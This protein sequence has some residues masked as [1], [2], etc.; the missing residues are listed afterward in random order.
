MS[1]KKTK[2]QFEN[3]KQRKWFDQEC[4]LIK[5]FVP[6]THFYANCHSLMLA[7]AWKTHSICW[8]LKAQISAICSFFWVFWI[9]FP[10]H[11]TAFSIGAQKYVIFM[12]KQFQFSFINFQY[13]ANQTFSFCCSIVCDVLFLSLWSTL[14]LFFTFQHKFHCCC[15]IIFIKFTMLLMQNLQFYLSF[16]RKH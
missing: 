15:S 16:N 1:S 12:Y 8:K 5:N 10:F 13:Y 2:I 9:L 4:T 14:M 3:R 6:K 7:L 11:R